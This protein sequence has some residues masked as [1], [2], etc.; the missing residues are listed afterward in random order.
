MTGPLQI[1]ARH[2]FSFSSLSPPP[3]P[4]VLEVAET[5]NEEI[6]RA[7][8]RERT[9]ASSSIREQHFSN[10]RIIHFFSPPF[11]LGRS[12]FFT[13][14]GWMVFFFSLSLFSF[15]CTRLQDTLVC[16]GGLVF[17]V[18][19][20]F[21][22]GK[23]SNGWVRMVGTRSVKILPPCFIERIFDPPFFSRLIGR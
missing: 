23:R 22:G 11:L 9:I 16:W 10:R 21:E 19:I 18:L 7:R 4:F 15:E 3:S 6:E 2:F 12:F 8:E 17:E 13:H 14:R 20:Q 5:K 1:I